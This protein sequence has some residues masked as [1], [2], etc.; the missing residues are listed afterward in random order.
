MLLLPELI[1]LM[2]EKAAT[3]S[4]I[5]SATEHYATRLDEMAPT[6]TFSESDLSLAVC[7]FGQGKMAPLS[8]F[9]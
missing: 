7:L 3:G 1:R 6:L 2:K 8:L 5:P 4:E 9:E